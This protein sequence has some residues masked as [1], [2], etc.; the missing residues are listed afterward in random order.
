MRYSGPHPVPRVPATMIS[1]P[2]MTTTAAQRYAVRTT[3]IALIAIA[4]W[5]CVIAKAVLELFVNSRLGALGSRMNAN[6]MISATSIPS[7]ID[8]APATPMTHRRNVAPM[9]EIANATTKPGAGFPAS[10]GF[11]PR[12][13]I[14]RRPNSGGENQTAPM[15]SALT[16]ASTIAIQL[17]LDTSKDTTASDPRPAQR[18]KGL[19][20]SAARLSIVPVLCGS[21]FARRHRSVKGV[22]AIPG[23]PGEGE[24]SYDQ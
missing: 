13:A 3:P 18:L 6:Q 15:I 14:Q 9:M 7:A 10:S 17:K 22:A 24:G 12:A 4:C 16:P 5:T 8:V 19:I 1:G 20:A 2:P 11:M 21:G 23:R